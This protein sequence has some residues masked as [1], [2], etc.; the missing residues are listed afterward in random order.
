MYY[1]IQEN[2]FRDTHYHLIIKAIQRLQLDYEIV[3]LNETDSFQVKTN[4]KD[5]FCFGSIKLA[6]LANKH[7]WFPGSL[8]NENHDY[9]VYSQYWKEALLNWNSK[10]QTIEMPIIF[11]ATPKFIRPT[12]DSKIFNG[13]LFNAQKWQETVTRL[14]KN[15]HRTELIQVAPPQKIYQEIRYWVIDA[16]VIAASSYKQGKEV[17]YIEYNDSQGLNFANQM[18]KE[19]QPAEAFVLDICLSE[20]G[21]KIVEVNCINSAGF[22]ACNLQ[23]LITELE[24]YYE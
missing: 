7:S 1:I 6:R 9:A 11:G 13:G 19:Y 8:M 22:Y 15:G 20:N 5:V 16:K 17:R 23:K 4:R 12:K 3:Q 21:W 18:A 10:V 2:V 24:N 14:L